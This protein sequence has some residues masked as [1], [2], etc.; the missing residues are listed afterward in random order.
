MISETK[1]KLKHPIRWILLGLLLTIS[2]V[3]LIPYNHVLEVEATVI[4]DKINNASSQEKW[5]SNIDIFSRFSEER[6]SGPY[7][8][9]FHMILFWP[10]EV[11]YGTTLSKSKTSPRIGE[12]THSMLFEYPEQ[13]R[14][15][16]VSLWKYGEELSIQKIDR[17][18]IR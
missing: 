12:G 14:S 15:L 11:P 10:D 2:V 6:P 16:D 8:L 9:E 5:V 13:Y 4:S 7:Q 18:K 3:L 17:Y 1:R